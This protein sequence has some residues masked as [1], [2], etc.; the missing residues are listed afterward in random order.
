MEHQCTDIS[1][2]LPR[3]Y[4]K[5]YSPLCGKM[6]CLF[7]DLKSP[8]CV[9]IGVNCSNQGLDLKPNSTGAPAVVQRDWWHLGSAGMKV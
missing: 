3:K 9:S 6:L 4:D 8:I 2:I 7:R 1:D 5:V